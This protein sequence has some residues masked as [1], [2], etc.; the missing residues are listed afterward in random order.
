[1]KDLMYHWIVGNDVPPWS[2]ALARGIFGAFIIG[3]FAGFNAWAQTDD[4]AFIIRSTGIAVFGWLGVRAGI[5]GFI[6]QRK[7]GN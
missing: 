5:E 2:V 4:L 3:G 1:M 7:N 6:D